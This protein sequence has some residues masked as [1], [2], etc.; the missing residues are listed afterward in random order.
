MLFTTV[1]THEGHD[2]NRRVGDVLALVALREELL[3]L[4]VDEQVQEGQS[5]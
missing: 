2:E 3:L 1:R 4:A 5:L